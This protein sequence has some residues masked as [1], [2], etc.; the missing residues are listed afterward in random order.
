[1]EKEVV[2]KAFTNYRSVEKK[3]N[4][5]GRQRVHGI[6]DGENADGVVMQIQHTNKNMI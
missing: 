1:M 3:E 4:Q 6:P 5:A 2:K